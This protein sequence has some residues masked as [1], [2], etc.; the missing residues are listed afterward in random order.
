MHQQRNSFRNFSKLENVNPIITLEIKPF[1]MAMT[2]KL[3][4]RQSQKLA[5]TPQLR[6]AIKLLQ[7]SNIELAEFVEEQLES[8][9]L[10]ERGTGDEN[11][12]GEAV[13]KPETLDPNSSI[14]NISSGA[15]EADLDAPDHAK[16]S[17]ATVADVGGTVD[18]SKSNSSGSFSNSGDYDVAANTA[19][20]VSLADHIQGQRALLGLAA[21][22]GLIADY[23]IGQL[24][25]AG[26]LRMS[27][28]EVAENLGAGLFARNLEECLSLQLKE[29]QQLDGP[30]KTMLAN[31]NLL[32]KHDLSKLMKV[33]EVGREKLDAMIANLR[34]CAPKPG[35][36]Y[37][38]TLAA[39]VEPD[40]FI[41]ETPNGG[42]AVELN[43]DTLPRVLVN[44]RYYNEIKRAGSKDE[45]AQEFI[46]ECHQ[47]A[48]WLV[49]S[50]DQRA[51][52]ILKVASEIVKQQDGFF[53]YGARS[54]A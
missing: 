23:M 7:Y 50:L 53:A 10:L 27:I 20:E 32:A 24:D 4:A 28:E 47:S 46:S 33:C 30:T 22:D 18:W 2:P 3:Q 11:R 9:P 25:E 38:G 45:K 6:Q 39:I 35:A 51:R 41:R 49:K 5:M 42:W 54:A 26:Y 52:T 21:R 17:E 15:K 36:V 44:N 19:A 14:E 37:G 43:A 31:L 1:Y 34:N 48:N 8:N 12:R 13:S 16:D 29:K 40:V